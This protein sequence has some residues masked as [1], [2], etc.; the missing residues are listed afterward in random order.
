MKRNVWVKVVFVLMFLL[1]V[2]LGSSVQAENTSFSDEEIKAPQSITLSKT[3]VSLIVYKTAQ[4]TAT[5]NPIE[6]ADQS[7]SWISTNPKIATVNQNGE[8]KAVKVGTTIITV[9]SND[10]PLIKESI[11]VTVTKIVPTSLKLSKASLHIIKNQTVNAKATIAPSN[12]ANKTV[13]WKSSNTKAAKV[14]S[15]GNIKGIANGSA[16]ITATAQDNSK[17]YKRVTVKVSTKTV[18]INKSSLTV[19]TGK[20]GQLTATV[21]PADSTNKGVV[22]STSNKKIATVS[23]KGKVTGKSKGTATITATVKGAKAVKIK[24]SVKSPIV[25]SSVKL[26]KTSTSIVQGK[27]LTLLATVSPSKAV[28]KTVKWSSSNKKIA[29]VSSK[30]KVT[31]VG[32]GTAKITATTTNGKKTMATIKVK[33]KPYVKTLRAGT[34]KAGK[35]IKTGRY[36]ITTSFGNGNLFITGN[37]YFDSNRYINEIL[38]GEDDGFGVKVVTTDLK[39][40]DEIEILSLDSVKFTRISHV[41]SSTLTA[42]YHTVGKDIK[43]GKYKMTTPSGSGNL[44]IY[45]GDNLLVNEILSKQADKYTVRSVTKT[46]KAGDQINISSLEKVV[47]TKK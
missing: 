25:P 2:S 8:I 26:N 23:S 13:R 27:T 34:W 14:D 7:V 40:G 18:K 28:N 4:L 6:T 33:A 45:R 11:K 35:D 20:T 9:A 46:L 12:A 17:V 42:G 32:V 30:G 3:A 15:N 5:V 29:T 47:F 1:S 38:T 10:N 21:S 43:A 37:D 19:T 22:W 24:V 41:L 39:S 16:T 31:A 44:V 36:K